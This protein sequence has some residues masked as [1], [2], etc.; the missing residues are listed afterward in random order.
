MDRAIDDQ[1]NDELKDQ[2]KGRITDETFGVRIVLGS[3]FSR[4]L[5][6]D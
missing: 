4:V 3:R 2:L 6:T 1:S 5:R